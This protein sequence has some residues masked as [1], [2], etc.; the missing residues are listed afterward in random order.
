[1]VQNENIAKI[2]VNLIEKGIKTLDNVPE[3]L[4]ESVCILLENNSK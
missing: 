3:P 1:M 4:K 2:Y